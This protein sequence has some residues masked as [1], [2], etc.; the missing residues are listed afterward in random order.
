MGE[1]GYERVVSLEAT[2]DEVWAALTEHEQLGAWF[3]GDLTLEARPG[4]RVVLVGDDGERRHG[5]IEVIDPGRRLV[6]RWWEPGLATTASGTRVDLELAAGSAG[7]TDL[8]VREGTLRRA[9][10]PAGTQLL[11]R[12]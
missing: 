10:G 11:A 1:S 6:F 12:V 5:T 4:G 7:G 2:P 9:H 3:G 8:T